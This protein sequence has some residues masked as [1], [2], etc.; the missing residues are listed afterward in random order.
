MGIIIVV[1]VKAFYLISEF[2]KRFA[3]DVLGLKN[4]F[5]H[6]SIF[7]YLWALTSSQCTIKRAVYEIQITPNFI[8]S[9]R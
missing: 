2:R 1:V 4:V 9:C 3:I 8:S 6:Y 7:H 5:A